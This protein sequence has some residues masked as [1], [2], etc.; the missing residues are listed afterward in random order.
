MKSKFFVTVL[1]FLT[2]LNFSC[3]LKYSETPEVSDKVP[4]FIFNDT[5]ITKYENSKEKMKITAQILEQYKDSSQSYAQQ[6]EFYSFDKKGKL[7]TEGKCGLLSLNTETDIY[8]MFD[9]IEV[10]NHEENTKFFAEVL[11]WN[12]KN[13]QL[14]SG[15][16]NVVTVQKDDTII[17]GSGFSASGI[18]KSFSFK[19]NVTGEILTK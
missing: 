7:E 11:R 17:K 16:G 14:T 9:N 19:G 5:S 2:I 4:E 10:L 8:E 3:S 12:S 13:E 1:L 15:R 6:V 18:S